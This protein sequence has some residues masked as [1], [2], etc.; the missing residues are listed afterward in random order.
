LVLKVYAVMADKSPE[1]CARQLEG[2]EAGGGMREDGT[3]PFHVLLGVC[4]GHEDVAVAGADAW[5]GQ[6]A[7]CY[8]PCRR[9]EVY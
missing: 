6:W 4:Y 3:H 1:L 2:E 5:D 7:R 9:G 8:K